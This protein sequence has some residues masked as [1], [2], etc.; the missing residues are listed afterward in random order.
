MA[1][2]AMGKQVRKQSAL[3][4]CAAGGPALLWVSAPRFSCCRWSSCGP[5]ATL[6]LMASGVLQVSHLATWRDW[7]QINP[8]STYMSRVPILNPLNATRVQGRGY[9]VTLYKMVV[10]NPPPW[11][12]ASPILIRG[13]SKTQGRKKKQG[14]M[15]PL[16]KHPQIIH[17]NRL[18]I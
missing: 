9:R 2:E 13:M 10:G 5:E 8:T 15:H 11:I 6:R 7:L 1:G 14:F 16:V 3:G 4:H 18:Q 12:W 17:H